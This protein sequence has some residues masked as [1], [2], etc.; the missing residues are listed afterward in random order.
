VSPP[1][2]RAVETA[3]DRRRFLTFPWTIYRADP[4]WV[5]PLLPDRA[6]DLDPRRGAFFRRGGAAAPL[7]AWRDGRVV[8]TICP[9]DDVAQNAAVRART[10]GFG[11][12]ECVDDAAVA[13]ALFAAAAAWARG[14]GLDALVGP[15]HL[16]Y[17][18]GHGI[19]V[20]GRDRPPALL[21]GHTPPYYQRLVERFGFVP[22]RPDNIAYAI[23]FDAPQ[24]ARLERAAA[25]V[26]AGTRVAIRTP[27]LRRWRD[28]IDVV[29]GLLNRSLAHL[30]DAM[31]Y[32]REQVEAL[33]EPFARIADPDLVLFAEVGGK[34]VGWFPALPNLN[35]ALI[36]ADGLR[37][38]WDLAR[39]AWH[40]RRRPRSVAIKSVLVLP[41]YWRRGVALLLF[42][43]M[44]RRATAK[45]YEWADLSLTSLENPHTPGLA[46]TLGARLYKR[47]RV[48]RLLLAAAGRPAPSAPAEPR[49]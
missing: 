24:L 43:E 11:F 3:G 12:F 30:S 44:K 4:L 21:C 29:L 7:L 37:R 10:A 33:I 19:L 2:V 47:Y 8:G 16:D 28:E 22:E 39:L 49:A 17:E 27:D 5:P 46:E 45:G 42:D 9:F 31:P 41:E 13:S 35:E 1:R 23:D 26:R 38:P 6:R 32:L 34:T 36:H 15:F 14:R 18:S 25:R 20:E 48:Y 40:L